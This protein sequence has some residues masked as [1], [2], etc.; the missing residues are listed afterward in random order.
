[1]KGK[2][3]RTAQIV[4]ILG[5]LIVLMSAG[6]AQALLI[7]S[8]DDT[9]HYVSATRVT[10]PQSNFGPAVVG[11]GVEI[12][13][14]YR[15]ISL[16]TVA[17]SSDPPRASM[18]TDSPGNKTLSYSNDDGVSSTARVVWDANG[19]GLG[20]ADL[21]DGD[22]STHLTLDI[23]DIDFGYVNIQFAVTDA[24]NNTSSIDITDASIG[25]TQVAFADFTGIANF[26]LVKSIEMTL[27]GEPARDLR[28]DTVYTSTLIPEP[29]TITLLSMAGV[30]LLGFRRKFK[31]S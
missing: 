12:I 3:L 22:T 11:G 23:I 6:S 28:L 9:Y 18:F 15:F 1:M 10:A 29:A 24:S 13:G 20:S 25:I 26:H 17:A 2:M 16:D 27:Q 5:C 14:D 8:F 7:D 30:G 21:T 31:K 19:A 4:G